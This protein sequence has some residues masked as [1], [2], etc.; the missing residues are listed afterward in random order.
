[1]YWGI[2]GSKFKVPFLLYPGIN[3]IADLEEKVSFCLVNILEVPKSILHCKAQLFKSS[4]T[5]IVSEISLAKAALSSANSCPGIR[6]CLLGL[7]D[8]VVLGTQIPSL[9]LIILE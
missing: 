6:L 2:L 9:C 7:E 8:I 4:H 1:M 5:L 3:N